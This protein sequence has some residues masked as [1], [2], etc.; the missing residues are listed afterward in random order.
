MRNQ[1]I[2]I[3]D[4]FV[5]YEN[6]KYYMYGTRAANFGIRTG[7]F[8]V[9]V[10]E[11]LE[12]WSDPIPCFDSEAFGLNR[13]ANWA[14]E[15]HRY[16]GAYYM[17]ATFVKENGG[18]G[19]YALRSESLLG[20]FLPHS[21]GAL[22]PFEWECLD[23]TLFVNEEGKPFLVFCHEHTQIID[24]TIDFIP[25]S[26]DLTHAVGEV[27]TLF[28]ASSPD[29]ADQPVGGKH[30]ITDG[31]YMY[32]SKT[33]ELFMLWSTFINDK[34]A[35][36]L[37]SFEDGKLGMKFSHMEPLIRDDGGHG[38]IFEGKDGLYLTFHTPNTKG[39]EKPAFF[40]LQD[41]GDS[42]VIQK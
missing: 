19:T 42:L 12:N 3:R 37:V 35:E 11:D 27:T 15:V 23:G 24:G 2:N 38:M 21:N 9:Y 4:P 40:R 10:S 1:D 41:H 22:T 30:V 33:G 39:Q 18:R 25:L 26:D 13:G 20:P 8:D 32:R 14:P 17:F 31:P 6:G 28:K 16:Q 34:Y 36:C 5:V 29:F 7:G